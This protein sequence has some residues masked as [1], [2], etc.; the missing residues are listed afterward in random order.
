MPSS[1]AGTPTDHAEILVPAD[2]DDPS[3][4]LLATPSEQLLDKVLFIRNQQGAQITALQDVVN[5]GWGDFLIGP[6]PV[7]GN[8]W[9]TLVVASGDTG[10]GASGVTVAEHTGTPTGHYIQL[11]N[12]NEDDAAGLWEIEVEVP[13]VATT[14]G[15]KGLTLFRHDGSS[16]PTS[17]E[18]AVRHFVAEGSGVVLDTEGFTIRGTFR[19]YISP[20][21]TDAPRFSLQWD[22]GAAATLGTSIDAPRVYVTQLS[23]SL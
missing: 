15:V 23:R 12:D 7:V 20:G 13:G 19:D 5:R 14:T 9:A 16:D 3:G 21:I 11:G 2:S 4:A 18:V 17:G 10:A 6:D 1:Y 8:G 22:A